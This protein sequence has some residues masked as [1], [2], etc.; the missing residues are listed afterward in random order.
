M[1]YRATEWFFFFG[2]QPSG[3]NL[4]MLTIGWVNG[5]VISS[6]GCSFIL[7]WRIREQKKHIFIVKQRNT[8]QPLILR[9]RCQSQNMLSLLSNNF[10]K[11]IILF[12]DPPH[13]TTREGIF[14]TVFSFFVTS[15]DLA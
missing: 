1:C 9:R 5:K 14:I 4:I 7:N 12:S 8:Y 15:F 10:Q 2:T 6:N 3:Y 11:L 13:C